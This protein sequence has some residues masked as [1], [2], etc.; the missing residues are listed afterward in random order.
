MKKKHLTNNKFVLLICFILAFSINAHSQ[1]RFGV[2]G[3]FDV[4][5]NRINKDILNTSN[6]LGYQIGGTLEVM[7]PIVG[8]G[9]ELSVLYGHQEYKIKGV[10]NNES[11][12]SYNLSDYNFIRVPLNLK[13]KFSILGLVGGFIQAGPYIEFKLKGADLTKD[14]NISEQYKSKDFGAGINAGAGISFLK[15]LELGMY[16]RKLLTENYKEDKG[17]GDLL[18]KRPDNWS[19]GLT[20]YF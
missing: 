13:K 14:Q 19:V 3:A 11:N 20:Y 6:R 4:V 5:N 8:W 15:H 9:G 16:Y 18:K 7:A 12:S 10:K 1:I 2:K 17:W